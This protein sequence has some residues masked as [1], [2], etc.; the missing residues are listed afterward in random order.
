MDGEISYEELTVDDYVTFGRPESTRA[1][2]Y[3]IIV[4][5]NRQTY[6]IK[7]VTTWFQVKRTYPQGSKFRVSKGMV[8][9]YMAGDIDA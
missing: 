6:T 5:V 4:K 3:G 9:R 1:P 7:L 8:T 2:A